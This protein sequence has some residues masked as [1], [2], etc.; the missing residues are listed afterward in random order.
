MASERL[1]RT[2][3][4]KNMTIIREKAILKFNIYIYIIIYCQSILL[5]CPEN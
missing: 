3:Q 5:G 1:A 2:P 4:L